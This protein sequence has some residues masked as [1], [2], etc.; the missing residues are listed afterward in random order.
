[1]QH[2]SM[3]ISTRTS[4]AIAAAR[5]CERKSNE[6]E[7]RGPSG[8]RWPFGPGGRESRALLPYFGSQLN[9]NVLYA[10]TEAE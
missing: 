5:R 9:D 7:H 6:C 3:R 10:Q 2:A 1:M 4:G 8:P